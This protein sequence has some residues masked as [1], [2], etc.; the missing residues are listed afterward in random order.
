MKSPEV[1]TTFKIVWAERVCIESTSLNFWSRQLLTVLAIG[2]DLSSRRFPS[3]DDLA[4]LRNERSIG[5]VTFCERLIASYP[6]EKW[7]R[8]WALRE[9]PCWNLPCQNDHPRQFDERLG[10]ELISY[11]RKRFPSSIS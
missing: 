9:Q 2:P 7:N 3:F 6:V 10:K 11:L 5:F 1:K 8:R 4:V